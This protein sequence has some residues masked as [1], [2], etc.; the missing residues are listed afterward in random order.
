MRKEFSK[1]MS[2]MTAYGLVS[3]GVKIK[4]T[5]IKSKNKNDVVMQ[6]QGSENLRDNL[7]NIFGVKIMSALKQ[8]VQAELKEE[9]IKEAGIKGPIPEV[10]LVGFISSPVHGEGRGLFIIDQHATDEK[11]NFETLQK[12]PNNQDKTPEDGGSSDPGTD[13]SQ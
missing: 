4:V 10:K 12:I 3:S 2:V 5:N 11:Y 8:I 7:I 13:F 9:D 6:S 1:L